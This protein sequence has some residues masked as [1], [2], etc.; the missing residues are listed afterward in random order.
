MYGGPPRRNR[1][2]QHADLTRDI[3]IGKQRQN[4]GTINIPRILKIADVFL[5][6]QVRLA[7]LA[8]HI[9]VVFCKLMRLVDRLGTVRRSHLS[10]YITDMHL[11]SALAHM[12]IMRNNLIRFALP[13][14]R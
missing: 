3:S 7:H 4:L 8:S 14:M 11:N 10:H 6:P 9:L 5:L 12:E 13:K 2:R 1:T